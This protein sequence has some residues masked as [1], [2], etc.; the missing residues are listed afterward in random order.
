[1]SKELFDWFEQAQPILKVWG[2]YVVSTIEKRVKNEIGEQRFSSFFK[3]Q[4]VFRVKTKESI[5]EKI[6][7]KSYSDPR[8][9][10]TDFVG[11]RFVVLLKSDLEVLDRAIINR[12]NWSVSKDRDFVNESLK[13]PSVF[14]YQSN[15]YVITNSSDRKVEGVEIPEGFRCEIQTR[16]LLQH[17]YAELVHADIYKTN[18]FVPDSTKRLVARSMALMESTDDVFVSISKELE[19]IRE[20]QSCLYAA[21]R[22]IY[23]DMGIDASVDASELFLEI[24]GTYRDLLKEVSLDAL[25]AVVKKAGLRQKIKERAQRSELFADPTTL[26]VYWLIECKSGRF[27]R[28]WERFD[29]RLDVEQ[30]ASDL[31]KSFPD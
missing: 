18:T 11:V 25:H 6:T 1:M 23:L 19:S 29:L 4:P 8:E 17:A 20:A 13:E 26:L 15:H 21:S 30:A 9:Q 28:G 10:I 31:G 16:S 24:A 22:L 27:F 3:I 5:E 7:R 14:D 12:N 2:R